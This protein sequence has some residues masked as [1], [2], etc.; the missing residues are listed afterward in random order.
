MAVVLALVFMVDAL[1]CVVL[2]VALGAAE[3][4][5]GRVRKV[6]NHSSVF[7]LYRGSENR[8]LAEH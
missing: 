2:S 8:P 1:Q 5:S 7:A 3:T 4:G 6:P